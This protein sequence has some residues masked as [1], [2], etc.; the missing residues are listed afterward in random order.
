MVE[1]YWNLGKRVR[2]EDNLKKYFNGTYSKQ[3]EHL[4]QD[5]GQKIGISR[6]TLYYALQFYDKYPRLDEPD[7]VQEWFFEANFWYLTRNLYCVILLPMAKKVMI[8]LTPALLK[9]GKLLAAARGLPFSKLIAEL[10]NKDFNVSEITK[11]AN[12]CEIDPKNLTG[13]KKIE[14]NK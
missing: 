6:S 13:A 2:E 10:I 7:Y 5:L 4:V 14:P 8:T 11:S 9:K 12:A 1:G 3:L